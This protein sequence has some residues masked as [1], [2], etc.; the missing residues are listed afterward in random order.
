MP[1]V[2]GCANKVYIFWEY[3][4]DEFYFTFFQDDI[5]QS[6]DKRIDKEIVMMLKIG[7]ILTDRKKSIQ[8]KVNRKE[9]V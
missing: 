1:V 8:C 3:I 4:Q 2:K 5:D 9:G 7:Q 6:S